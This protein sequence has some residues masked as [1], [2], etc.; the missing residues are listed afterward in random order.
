MKISRNAILA[1]NTVVGK[2][3]PDLIHHF[4]LLSGLIHHF[5]QV[6][7]SLKIPS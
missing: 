7:S 4:F 6:K 3:G 2:G 5:L 1:R